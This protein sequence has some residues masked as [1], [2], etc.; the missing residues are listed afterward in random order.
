MKN[1]KGL[2]LLGFLVKAMLVIGFLVFIVF[3]FFIRD[4]LKIEEF[5]QNECLIETAEDYCEDNNM[6][7]GNLSSLGVFGCKETERSVNF[8]LFKFTEEEMEKCK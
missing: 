2:G 1:K 3:I 4:G 6:I 7:Y 8:K 5:F